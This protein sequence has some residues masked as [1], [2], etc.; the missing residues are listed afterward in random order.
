[1]T[2]P[3]Y[4]GTLTT[5]EY[6]SSNYIKNNPNNITVTTTSSDSSNGNKISIDGS[7]I[8]FTKSGA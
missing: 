2:A 3:K 1:L 6:V 8:I 7:N 4:S 5:E